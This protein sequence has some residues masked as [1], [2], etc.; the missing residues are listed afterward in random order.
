M[1]KNKPI[2]KFKSYKEE[3]NFWDTHNTIE[4]FDYSKAIV[5]DPKKKDVLT[6][7]L[8]STD[9]NVIRKIAKEKRLSSSA[10]VR[11][12]IAENINFAK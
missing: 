3:A 7:K 1:N 8:S 11:T 2:P 10:L 4:Y 12:W 6:I 5:V 9:R